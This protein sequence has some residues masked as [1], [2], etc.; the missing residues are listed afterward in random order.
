MFIDPSFIP[1]HARTTLLFQ[2]TF[3]CCEQKSGPQI[4]KYAHLKMTGIAGL[5]KYHGTA[6]VVCQSALY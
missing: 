6:R 2:G 4:G 5:K 3:Q 1:H